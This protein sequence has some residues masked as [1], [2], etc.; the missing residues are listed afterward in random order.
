[1]D[2]TDETKCKDLLRAGELTAPLPIGYHMAERLFR[3]SY[4]R[5]VGSP[6]WL[7]AKMGMDDPFFV[8]GEELLSTHKPVYVHGRFV[9]IDQAEKELR[10]NSDDPAERLQRLREEHHRRREASKHMAEAKAREAK[11]KQATIA[12]RQAE[13]RARMG[14]APPPEATAPSAARERTSKAGFG[15]ARGTQ[16]A[17]KQDAIARR[18]AEI[19]ARMGKGAAQPAA[20]RP[21]VASS[22]DHPDREVPRIPPRGRQ[23]RVSSSGRIRAGATPQRRRR[24]VVQGG[25]PPGGRPPIVVPDDP[26]RDNPFA[27]RTRRRVHHVPRQAPATPE[28]ADPTVAGTTRPGSTPEPVPAAPE[29]APSPASSAPEPT[30]APVAPQPTP[31]P[32][33]AAS[34]MDDLFGPPKPKAPVDRMPR[35][36]AGMEDL[37]GGMQEGRLRIGRRSRKKPEPEEPDD[38]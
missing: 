5:P 1:M 13:T 34:S 25:E 19:R 6:P 33:P 2:I 30:P 37:F 22:D 28:P 29:P 32:Q 11:Q 10:K 8:K 23:R 3:R 26:D 18:Q 27:V 38:G 4:R 15:Q 20:R 21:P 14:I 16:G 31:G 9:R 17:R 35:R 12:Q 7:F 36:E 24:K